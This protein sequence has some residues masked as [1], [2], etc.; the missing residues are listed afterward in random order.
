MNL[1]LLVYRLPL[2]DLSVPSEGWTDSNNNSDANPGELVEYS[3]FMSNDGSVS[4]HDLNVT[5]TTL[6]AEDIVCPT[7]PSGIFEPGA[8]IT[9]SATYE[10]KW[11]LR[12]ALN[13]RR[14][15][16]FSIKYARTR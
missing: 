1:Q 15:P 8:S 4:L 16:T 5:S 12:S 2:A 14:I 13:P 11:L 3:I 10:V 6:S 9:C 7:L